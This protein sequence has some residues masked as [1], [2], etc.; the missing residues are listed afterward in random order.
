M[1]D[2]KIQLLVF[3]LVESEHLRRFDSSHQHA[4]HAPHT[5]ALHAAQEQ[6]ERQR[7]GDPDGRRLPAVPLIG[8]NIQ[9]TVQFLHTS[10][11]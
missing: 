10:D 11:S 6:L 4:S 9:A 5:A 8:T 7:D 2:A 1:V 3:W